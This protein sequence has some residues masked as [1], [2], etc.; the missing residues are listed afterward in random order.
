[1][2]Q[3]GAQLTIFPPYGIRLRWYEKTIAIFLPTNTTGHVT[4]KFTL[5]F[6][7]FLGVICRISINTWIEVHFLVLIRK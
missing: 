7:D 5:I 4:E 1:M 6:F 2:C 3:P